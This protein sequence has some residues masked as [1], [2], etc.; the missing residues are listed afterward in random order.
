MQHACTAAAASTKS[1]AGFAGDVPL[2][3][4]PT[5]RCSGTVHECSSR[6]Q[7]SRI[8]SSDSRHGGDSARRGRRSLFQTAN[9]RV[10]A[11]YDLRVIYARH[12]VTDTGWKISLNRGLDIFQKYEMNAAFSLTT[13]LQR[14][15]PVKGF[16][17][18]YLR[19]SEHPLSRHRMPKPESNLPMSFRLHRGHR[20]FGRPVPAPLPA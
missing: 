12:I 1:L 19:N 14:F 11:F 18:T 6:R 2:P 15:R 17:V 5:D 16:E 4:D 3:E 9:D 20:D 7:H 10:W 8:I 13:H